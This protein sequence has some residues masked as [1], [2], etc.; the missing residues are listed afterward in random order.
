[1]NETAQQQ[2]GTDHAEHAAEARRCLALVDSGDRRAVRWWWQRLTLGQSEAQ[3]RGLP[4]P[5][6]RGVRA[7]LRR[8]E[9]PD[10][11]VL[12]EGFRYLWQ[13]LPGEQGDRRRKH[14]I[15]AWA[16]VALIVAELRDEA[17]GMTAGRAFAT[18]RRNTGKPL[19]S[20]LRFQ[21]LQESQSPIDLIRR[22]RRAI[23]LVGHCN[24]SVVN[25]ADDV[26]LWHREH[27]ARDGVVAR[28]VEDRIAFRWANDYFTTLARYQR[29]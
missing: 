19:V 26:L 21:Q 3:R 17:P 2:T 1:M 23:A 7:I 12:T 5:W 14:N 13:L 11:A 29:D 16:C 22:M 28:R 20:E 24:I 9:T 10:A 27:A 18:E 25:V 4:P 6:P 8:C 15:E